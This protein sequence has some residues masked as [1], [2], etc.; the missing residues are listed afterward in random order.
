MNKTYENLSFDTVVIGGGPAGAVAA[1]AAKT[2]E[3]V[4]NIS[5]SL[6]RET[7]IRDGAFLTEYK[8]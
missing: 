8:E 3:D 4:K 6:L 1:I 5:I 2:G 7:L